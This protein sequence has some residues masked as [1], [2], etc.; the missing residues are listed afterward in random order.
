[1][2]LKT[3]KTLTFTFRAQALRQENSILEVVVIHAMPYGGLMGGTRQ[4]EIRK[5]PGG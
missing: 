1:M 4:R 5:Q 2:Y 3:Y